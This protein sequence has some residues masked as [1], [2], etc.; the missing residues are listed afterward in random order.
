MDIYKEVT[1][2]MNILLNKKAKNPQDRCDKDKSQVWFNNYEY[3]WRIGHH[4]LNKELYSSGYFKS[5]I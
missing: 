4:H 1:P 2:Q 3:Y 5:F